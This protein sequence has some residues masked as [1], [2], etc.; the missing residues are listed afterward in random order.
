MLTYL[1]YKM[2]R[3][4]YYMSMSVQETTINI[5]ICVTSIFSCLI[6]IIFILI[7]LI[8]IML[9]W[10]KFNLIIGVQIGVQINLFSQL[11]FLSTLTPM[12]LS[13]Q[14]FS[15]QKEEKWRKWKCRTDFLCFL[16]QLQPESPFLENPE[17][18]DKC[19]SLQK[20]KTGLKFCYSSS[21]Y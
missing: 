3:Y 11:W 15:L 14:Q 13:G 10:T 5:F 2:I 20:K 4:R 16:N 7:R 19:Q 21:H 8:M 17:I 18:W 9:I 6:M 12:P 1:W